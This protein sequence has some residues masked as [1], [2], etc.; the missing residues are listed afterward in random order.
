MLCSWS[1]CEEEPREKPIWIVVVVQYQS[2]V[3]NSQGKFQLLFT[4]A[5][6]AGPK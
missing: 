2:M 3:A 4:N 5:R 6:V 1:S